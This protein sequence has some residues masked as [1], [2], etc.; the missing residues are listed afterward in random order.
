M[1][2]VNRIMKCH[3]RIIT[4]SGLLLFSITLALVSGDRL[5]ATTLAKSPEA[6]KALAGL[7]SLFAQPAF[8]L[9]CCMLVAI[10]ASAIPAGNRI[11]HSGVFCFCCSSAALT[12]SLLLKHVIGRARPNAQL[13]FDPHVFSPFAFDDAFASFPSAQAA[14]AAAAFGAAFKCF[15]RLKSLFNIWIAILCAARILSGEHWLSDVM[16]GWAIG[17]FCATAFGRWFKPDVNART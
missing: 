13:A 17:T 15:P 14:C 12:V 4:M 11:S 10:I 7:F 9:P 8:L 1:L 6:V 16:M 3:N 2:L 5:I